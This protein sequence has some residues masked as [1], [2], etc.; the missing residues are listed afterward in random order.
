MAKRPN[1]LLAMADQLA[2]QVLP[3]CG[4][5]RVTTPHLDRLAEEGV[6]FGHR[7]VSR[8]RRAIRFAGHEAAVAC[9][10]DDGRPY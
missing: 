6:V 1:L 3:A 7:A 2:P 10:F 5:P 8:R 9:S 4:H